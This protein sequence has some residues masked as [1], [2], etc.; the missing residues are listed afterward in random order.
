[1]NGPNSEDPKE[2]NKKSIVN[3][4]GSEDWPFWQRFGA[5]LINSAPVFL[6]MIATFC[7]MWYLGANPELVGLRNAYLNL[8]VPAAAWGVVTLIAGVALFAWAFPYFNYKRIMRKGT[9]LEKAMC[10]GLWG[11]IAI[12]IAIVIAS[13]A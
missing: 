3:M 5:N 11:M 4:E 2:M 12:A 8:V 1:M 13:V 9:P 6:W 10:M 7:I